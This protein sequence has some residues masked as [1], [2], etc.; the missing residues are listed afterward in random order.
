MGIEYK[1]EPYIII[2]PFVGTQPVE[3]ELAVEAS[4]GADRDAFIDAVRGSLRDKGPDTG[5][6]SAMIYFPDGT[7]C[8]VAPD[9]LPCKAGINSPGVT[10][11]WCIGSKATG[12]CN[13]CKGNA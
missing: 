5:I 10:V 7:Q 2:R 11:G 8:H 6:T 4:S 1:P 3:Y 13:G 9:Q 12:S